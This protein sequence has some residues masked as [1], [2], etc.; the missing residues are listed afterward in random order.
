[1]NRFFVYR[2]VFAWVLALFVV[3]F[4]G[5]AL[6]LLPVEQYPDVAP[7]SLTISAVYSGA[8]AHTLDRTVTSIIEDEMNGVDNF[9]YMSSQSRS[10]GTAQITVTLRPGTNLDV[11]LSQVQDRL[12]RVEPRLPLEVRQVG[13]SVTKAS[14]GFLMLVALQ[15]TDG[16]QSAVEL[17]N[18]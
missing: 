16:S 15:S 17:G 9:L 7:P 4:G 14:S 18:F 5:I 13:V 6:A 3:L 12:S 11:A 10:N 2:P 8:D 1:M